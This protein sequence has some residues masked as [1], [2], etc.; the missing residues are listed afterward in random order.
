MMI[1]I[2]A[3]IFWES[4][5]SCIVS[6]LQ[7]AICSRAPSRYRIRVRDQALAHFP[8]SQFAQDE[9]QAGQAP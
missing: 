5:I 9:P 6:G 7:A 1:V 4:W 8:D 3:V 2:V